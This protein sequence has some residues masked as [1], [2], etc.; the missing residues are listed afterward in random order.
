MRT[1]TVQG[2]LWRALTADGDNREQLDRLSAL[3]RR[4]IREELTERQRDAFLLYVGQG[5][6]QKEI[7]GMWVVHPSVV[8]RHIRRAEAHLRRWTEKLS[9][10][11]GNAFGDD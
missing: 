10:I 6:R 3:L 7:A 9:D 8:C 4:I 11:R 1:H 5:L 2:E